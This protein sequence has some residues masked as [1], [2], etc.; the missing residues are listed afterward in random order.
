VNKT[1]GAHNP[2]SSATPSPR[3]PIITTR[4]FIAR[5]GLNPE[6]ARVAIEY[7]L[8]QGWWEPYG[9]L[10]DGTPTYTLGPQVPPF[11]LMAW[12]S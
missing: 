2:E 10:P 3:K 9:V 11:V 12:Q 6:I 4:A 5:S 7:F 1:P 8:K